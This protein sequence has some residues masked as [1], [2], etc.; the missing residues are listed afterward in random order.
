MGS[1]PVVPRCM[2]LPVCDVCGGRSRTLVRGCTTWGDGRSMPAPGATAPIRTVYKVSC[3][4]GHGMDRWLE[5]REL[6]PFLEVEPG[7]ENEG[8]PDEAA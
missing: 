1:A 4:P 2:T 5:L 8:R 3:D 6:A 7:G